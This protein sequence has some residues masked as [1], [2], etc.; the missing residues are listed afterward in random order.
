[1]NNL[2][3]NV[4]YEH[5]HLIVINKRSGDIIQGDKTKDNKNTE[6]INATLVLSDHLTGCIYKFLVFKQ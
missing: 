6:N 5:N 1:M 3:I 4:I 2:P